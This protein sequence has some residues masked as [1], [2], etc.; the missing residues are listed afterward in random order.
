MTT[1]HR[2]NHGSPVCGFSYEETGDWPV[3][4]SWSTEYGEPKP[5]EQYC[6][7]CWIHISHRDDIADGS[8]DE[9]A[10]PLH[11]ARRTPMRPYDSARPPKKKVALSKRAWDLGEGRVVRVAMREPLQLTRENIAR[12][13]QYVDALEKEA[14]IGWPAERTRK[15]HHLP[16]PRH[17]PRT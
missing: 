12:L 5:G 14:S 13:R 6:H 3:D 10:D 4:H 2:L 7:Y 15:N 16:T 9:E 11:Y 17:R 8:G 1:I